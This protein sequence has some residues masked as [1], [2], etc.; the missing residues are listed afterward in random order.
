MGSPAQ[1]V[2][3]Q[4]LLGA[5]YHD[6]LGGGPSWGHSLGPWLLVAL[7]EM[8]LL[9]RTRDSRADAVPSSGQ[10]WGHNG[11]EG[12]C[13][14]LVQGPLPPVPRPKS[15]WHLC[16]ASTISSTGTRKRTCQKLFLARLMLIGWSR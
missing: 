8:E 15:D 12:A 9:E 10:L 11:H 7:R 14:G 6:V 2:K 13:Y 3:R 1:F 4:E 5:S 16:Y